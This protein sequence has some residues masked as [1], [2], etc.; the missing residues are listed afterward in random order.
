M[1]GGCAE[2]AWPRNGLEVDE[3]KDEAIASAGWQTYSSMAAIK[4]DADLDLAEIKSLLSAWRS[5]STN[6]PITSN[7]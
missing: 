1:G 2:P 6:S 3:L 4:E 7:L 5:R